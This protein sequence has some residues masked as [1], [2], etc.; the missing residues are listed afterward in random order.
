MRFACWRRNL[1]EC[2]GR[3]EGHAPLSLRDGWM[4]WMGDHG[5]GVDEAY[6]LM[7]MGEVRLLCASS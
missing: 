4:R 2:E 7:A 3:G 6:G 5:M 1:R